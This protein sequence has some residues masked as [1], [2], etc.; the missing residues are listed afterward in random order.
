MDSFKRFNEEK[1]P[2]KQCLSSSV[3]YETTTDSGKKLDSHISHK[4]YLSAKKFGMNLTWKIWV[5]ITIIKDVLLLVDIFE[6]FIDTCLKFFRL[7]PCHYFSSPGLNWDAMLKMTG[8]KLEKIFDI[9]MYL[10]IEKG[11]REGISYIVKRYA[12]ANTKYIKGYDPTKWSKYISY[13]DMNN[14]YGWAMSGYL[15]YDGFKWLRNVDNFDVNSI[16]EKSP[17]GYI[18][19][20]DLNYPNE[21]HVLHNYYPLAPEELAIS[22]DMLSDYCKKI[23]DEYEIKVGHV[24]QVIPNLGN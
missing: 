15:P 7:D 10:L 19:E 22:D 16:S 4:D 17:I 5:I 9:D 24:E 20:A 2:D 1:L 21:L 12:K 23:A 6:K 18:L 8:I 3:K 14:L 13:L 11:L